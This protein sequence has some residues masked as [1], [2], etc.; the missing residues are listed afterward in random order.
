M[1]YAMCRRIKEL[2]ENYKI[3]QEQMANVLEIT[4]QRYSCIEKGQ[5]EISFAT[6]KKIADFLRIPTSEITNAE[7]RKKELV[8]LFKK[9]PQTQ[10]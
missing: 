8:A 3:S 4:E 7:R 2:R 5:V 9:N 6:I 10:I 1:S